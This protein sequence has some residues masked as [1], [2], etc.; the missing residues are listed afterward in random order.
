MRNLRFYYDE[1]KKQLAEIKTFIQSVELQK[2]VISEL[3]I[4]EKA[5]INNLNLS[6]QY[7]K[8]IKQ[9]V[10]SPIQY[11]AVI[12]S[13][14]GCFEQYIDNIFEAYCQA[15][16]DTIEDYDNFPQKMKEKHIKKLGDFLSNPQRY[17]NYEL[18]NKQAV[19]NAAEAFYN[20]KEGFGNNKRLILTHGGNLKIEQIT[21]LASDLGIE[22]FE[23]NVVS[24]YVFKEYFINRE[25]FNEETYTRLIS[26]GSKRLFEI[27]DRLVEERNNVAHGWVES[28]IKL[29]DILNEYIDYMEC[30]AESILEVLIKS[31]HITQYNNDKMYLIG[32][33][34][35]VIDHHIVCINNQE[36]L[37]RKGDYLLA[38]KNDRFKV[39]TIR[40]LQKDGIDIEGVYEKNIDIGIGFE[41]RVD[42]NVDEEYEI[43]CER[44]L[45][46][47]RS[48]I[49]WNS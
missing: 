7:S 21:E 36:I 28:R 6:L 1:Y 46:N 26:S 47:A 17:K 9:V 14:Y 35:Q 12:I 23:R 22:D 18:T 4:S 8:I 13:V 15:L 31:I 38:V 29:S 41:K 30:L 42:L 16:Y 37:L 19:R 48:V 24:N 10:E 11:N 45:L 39:L 2:D 20:P 25:V 33:P 34:L 5:G 3:E 49:H 43:Y 44:E 40:T 32:K 27:L